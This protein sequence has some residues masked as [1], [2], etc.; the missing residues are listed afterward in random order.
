M[1]S[2]AKYQTHSLPGKTCTF[3]HEFPAKGWPPL[4]SLPSSYKSVLTREGVCL[5]FCG[6]VGT[7]N[8]LTFV[9]DCIVL[10][11]SCLLAYSMGINGSL[12]PPVCFTQS[13]TLWT[14]QMNIEASHSF[15]LSKET[16]A[17]EITT[18][19]EEEERAIHEETSR[20]HQQMMD[21]VSSLQIAGKV[22]DYSVN[23]L[24]VLTR[25]LTHN[26]RQDIFRPGL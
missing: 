8:C 10:Q 11:I 7:L 23:I 4:A 3:V 19:M 15:S 21:K 5:V 18:A 13:I 12:M 14:L 26:F 1:T 9:F 16:K 22:I 20:E 17:N 25:L 2:V 6:F 24:C